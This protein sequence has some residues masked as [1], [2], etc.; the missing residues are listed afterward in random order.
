M[1]GK[2]TTTT[3]NSVESGKA[4]STPKEEKTQEKA[5]KKATED[6]FI[7]IGP[8]TNTGIRENAMFL[9]TREDVEKHLDQTLEKYPQVK[10]LLFPT[11]SLAKARAKVRQSGTILN[12][13]YNDILS[14]QNKQ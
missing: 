11:E 6:T 12:K 2:R 5:N 4:E 10:L 1:A 13:Y 3:K 7:Y 8:T 9:G 14:L